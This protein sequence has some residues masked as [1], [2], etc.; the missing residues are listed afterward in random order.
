MNNDKRQALM[1]EAWRFRERA[2]QHTGQER[3]ARWDCGRGHEWDDS[4]DHAQNV[5][6]MSCASQRR[7]N[8]AKRFHDIARARGGVYEPQASVNTGASPGWACAHGHRWNAWAEEAERRWC[9]VCART[10]FSAYR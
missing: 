7:E 3:I 8:E 6:C 10:V 9:V 4:L 2:A 1:D 5:R